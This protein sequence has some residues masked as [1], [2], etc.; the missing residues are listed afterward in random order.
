LG[1]S[2]FL[3]RTFVVFTYGQLFDI[4]YVS[5]VAVWGDPGG[6]APGAEL[7]ASDASPAME[8]AAQEVGE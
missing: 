5:V 2:G 7:A 3:F 6:A 1:R 4:M 8:R